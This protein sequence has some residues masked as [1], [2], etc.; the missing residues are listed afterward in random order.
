MQG[1]EQVDQP[2]FV[3]LSGRRVPMK[4]SGFYVDYI[5]YLY[6]Q[7]LNYDSHPLYLSQLYI[8]RVVSEGYRD[9]KD[10]AYCQE[11]LRVKYLRDGLYSG[12]YVRGEVNED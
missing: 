11:E 3:H 1:F 9:P 6:P 8:K 4:E 10:E 2:L 12:L 7:G 5:G